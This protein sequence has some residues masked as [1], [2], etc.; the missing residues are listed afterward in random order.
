MNLM[1]FVLMI[2]VS[3]IIV[4]IGSVALELTGLEESIA[5]FQALS[6]FTGTGFTTKESELII[7]NP[8]RRRI[9]SFLM[10]LGHAGLVT[11]IATFANSLRPTVLTDK[12][13]LPFIHTFF[14]SHLLP[15]INLIIIIGAVY[16]IYK[17]FTHTNFTKKLTNILKTHILKKEIIKPAVYNEFLVAPSGYGIVQIHVL[18][19]SPV[20]NKIVSALGPAEQDFSLLAVVRE[21]KTIPNPQSNTK[22]VID[23]KLIC[24]GKMESIR[25]A[26]YEKQ[27]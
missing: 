17:L 3:M 6:C 1:L 4:Q 10:V 12:F 23:D 7:T 26:L 8:Q 9:A 11:L 18:K 14:P 13:K 27:K 24:F 19:G 15:W 5:R 2:V 16:V 25:N 21:G 20:I 22:I